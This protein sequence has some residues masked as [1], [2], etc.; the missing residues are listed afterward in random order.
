MDN[1]ETLDTLGTHDP[2]CRQ[3]KHKI[4][5]WW[6]KDKQYRKPKHN[7]T[8]KTC[9]IWTPPKTESERRC[10][11]IVSSFCLL[12]DTRYVTH[13][14]KTCV[15][16]ITIQVY[17]CKN[18]YRLNSFIILVTLKQFIPRTEYNCDPTFQIGLTQNHFWIA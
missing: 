13:I 17:V 7:T 16:D 3:T 1:P 9:T 18:I 6:V 11:T 8:Q 15:L 14:V 12:K 4:T 2:W 10:L 5:G